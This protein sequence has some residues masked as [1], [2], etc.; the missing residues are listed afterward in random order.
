MQFHGIYGSR[1]SMMYSTGVDSSGIDHGLENAKITWAEELGGFADNFQA[2]EYALK[3][4]NPSRPPT[5]REF[6]DLCRQ[7]PK[8]GLASL[9]YHPDEETQERGRHGIDAISKVLKQKDC[10]QVEHWATHPR[11]QRQ[12]DFICKAAIKN[13][14]IKS[15]VDKVIKAGNA[16]NTG[17][18]LNIYRDGAFMPC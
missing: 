13:A 11:C 15:C 10:S 14:L 9:P 3:N 16:S 6:L 12:W 5:S 1:F 17:K 18:L 4:I 7:A 2:I 8:I